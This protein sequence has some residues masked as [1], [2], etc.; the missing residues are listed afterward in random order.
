MNLTFVVIGDLRIYTIF[1]K[2]EEESKS[3]MRSKKD[4][5]NSLSLYHGSP[6][7][8]FEFL[9]K[10]HLLAKGKRVTFATPLI[11]IA[12][13]STQ[14]WTDDDFEQGIVDQDSPYMIEQYPNAFEDI[15]SGKSGYIYEL[16]STSFYHTPRLTRFEYISDK[17]PKILAVVYIED[18]LKLLKKLDIQLIPYDKGDSFRKMCYQTT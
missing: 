18:C 6:N 4:T 7:L 3:I 16:D 10:E 1:V 5:S 15:Y 17:A 11:Q 2:L 13:A 12:A 14:P 9:P 8:F